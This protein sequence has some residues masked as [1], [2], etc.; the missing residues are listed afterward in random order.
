MFGITDLATIIQVVSLAV[1]VVC[2]VAVFLYFAKRPRGSRETDQ[3]E[4]E[5]PP[6]TSNAIEQQPME[7]VV[8]IY[9]SESLFRQVVQSSEY[10]RSPQPAKP[11]SGQ[12]GVVWKPKPKRSLK[13]ELVRRV[14]E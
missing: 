9:V 14:E 2:G 7:P 13:E 12:E 5:P 11:M 6:R 3:F 1:A 10:R 8:P 4:R